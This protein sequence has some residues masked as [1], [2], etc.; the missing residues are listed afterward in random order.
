MQ[1]GRQ[2]RFL[3][4]NLSLLVKHFPVTDPVA[5]DHGNAKHSKPLHDIVRVGDLGNLISSFLHPLGS[6]S[7][8]C[9][10]RRLSLVQA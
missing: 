1:T 2:I 7:L 8:F 9:L 5:L 10:K 6:D 3:S 4:G